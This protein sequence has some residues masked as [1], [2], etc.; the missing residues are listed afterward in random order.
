MAEQVVILHGW[1]DNS[2][3]FEPLSRFLRG[4]GFDAVPVFLSDYISLRDDVKIDDVTKRMEEFIAERLALPDG[5]P[6][7]LGPRF[8]MVVHSTA[9]LVARRWIAR[10]YDGRPCPVV[11]LLMLAPAN[12]GSVL[13]HKGR[14]LLG[15]VVKGWKTGFETGEEM[16]YALELGSPFL[17]DLAR[18]DLFDEP[19]MPARQPLYGPERIRPFVIVG[20]RPY[21][22]LVTQLTNENGSDGTVRVA[23]A[24]LN[25]HGITVDFSAGDD[26]LQNPTITPWP[27][28]LGADVSFPLAVLPD[29]DHGSITRPDEEGYSKVPAARARLGEL[30]LQALRTGTP[31]EYRAVATAWDAISGDTR[32]FAGKSDEARAHR[33]AFFGKSGVSD[34]YFHEHYQV[35]LR[36]VDEFGAPVADYFVAFMPQRREAMFSLRSSLPDE[37]VFFHKEVLADVHKHRREPANVCMFMD[38]FDLMRDGGFYDQ[39]PS[40]KLVDLAF[41]VTAEDPGDR[42]SYFSRRRDARHGLVHLHERESPENRWLK[43]HCTHFVQLIVPRVGVPTTFSLR[44]A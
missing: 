6:E 16:L 38:R 14:S 34:Q 31:D 25:A 30:I 21:D 15:R 41:T 7:K 20:T 1:S 33:D 32:T 40:S 9:G 19:G 8:H 23:A 42:I 35:F 28:R 17:W 13:A 3:S 27:S 29:R 43:R 12:F 24:N 2:K 18:S 4:A 5:A 22:K 26:G 44:K 36:A 37:S 11:N 39:V 10:Y